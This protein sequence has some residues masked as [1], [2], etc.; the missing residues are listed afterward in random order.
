MISNSLSKYKMPGNNESNI[1]FKCPSVTY[2]LAP[3]RYFAVFSVVFYNAISFSHDLHHV[4]TV[5]MIS[6]INLV[7]FTELHV[8]VQSGAVIGQ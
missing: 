3:E 5:Q 7:K 6:T 4:Q 2:V 1:S 8:F